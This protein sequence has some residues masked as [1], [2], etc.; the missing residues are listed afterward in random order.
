MTILPSKILIFIKEKIPVKDHGAS[1]EN[2]SQHIYLP[3]SSEIKCKAIICTI[4]LL[5]EKKAFFMTV[6]PSKVA[7]SNLRI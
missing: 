6:L 4:R 3:E 1:E 2:F 5:Q 7:D